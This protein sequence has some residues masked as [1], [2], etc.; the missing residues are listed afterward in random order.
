MPKDELQRPVS[1]FI[2]QSID[3]DIQLCESL[4]TTTE[5][6]SLAREASWSLA[7]NIKFVLGT[8]LYVLFS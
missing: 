4:T 5:L 6:L 7:Q 1:S 8:Y 2:L 3:L